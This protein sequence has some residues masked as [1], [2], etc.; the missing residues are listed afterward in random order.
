LRRK[1]SEET[2]SEAT[3]W[4][5]AVRLRVETILREPLSIEGNIYK[6][7]VLEIHF[8]ESIFEA[9]SLKDEAFEENKALNATITS[10]NSM[11]FYYTFF[12]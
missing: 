9:R 3:T 5:R 6:A 12:Q 1:K 2:P 11:H 7:R 8:D 10:I 4:Y